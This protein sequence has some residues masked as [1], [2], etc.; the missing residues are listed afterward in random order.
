MNLINQILKTA[1]FAAV[2]VGPVPYASA[3]NL[4]NATDAEVHVIEISKFKFNP[5]Q[6]EVDVGDTIIW[7]N[8]DFVPHSANSTGIVFGTGSLGLKESYSL[9]LTVSGRYK[10]FCTFHPSMQG[11]VVVY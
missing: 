5:S 1:A 11:T 6:I 3:T 9:K 10:Y 8:L 2:I 4:T 7:V